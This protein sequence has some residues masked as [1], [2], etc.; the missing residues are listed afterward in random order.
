VTDGALV[1]L[2]AMTE[3]RV[4][5]ARKTMVSDAGVAGLRGVRR[6]LEIVH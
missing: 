6:Q 1:H 5:D 4:L 3:L 2:K